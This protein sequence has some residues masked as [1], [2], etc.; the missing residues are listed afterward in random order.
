MENVK[1]GQGGEEESLASADLSDGERNEEVR[2]PDQNEEQGDE[3]MEIDVN[4]VLPMRTFS[5]LG[6]G[7]GFRDLRQVIRA[8]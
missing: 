8:R 3:P 1:G 5:N 4:E 2:D 7:T 6:G